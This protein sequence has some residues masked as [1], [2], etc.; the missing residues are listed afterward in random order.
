[1]L[2]HVIFATMWTVI[3]KI[4]STEPRDELNVGSEN[5]EEYQLTPRFLTGANG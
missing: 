2:T 5:K 1:M 3:T 4:K